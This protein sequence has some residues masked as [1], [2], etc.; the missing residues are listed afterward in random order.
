VKNIKW[1]RKH[2]NRWNKAHARR[3][4]WTSRFANQQ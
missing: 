4:R 3:A 1:F 2:I